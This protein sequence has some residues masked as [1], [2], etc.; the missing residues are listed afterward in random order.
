M[1]TLLTFLD[2][3]KVTF[4]RIY[5]IN[6]VNF[7]LYNLWTK[8]KKN[9]T[10]KANKNRVFVFC[11][12]ITELIFTPHQRGKKATVGSCMVSYKIQVFLF[13]FPHT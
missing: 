12:A 6:P 13:I 10:E 4:F 1:A 9:N 8:S 3:K 5:F 2:Q 11:E 7:V